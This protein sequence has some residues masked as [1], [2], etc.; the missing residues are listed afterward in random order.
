MRCA[1]PGF[2]FLI[3]FAMSLCAQ[4]PPPAA[5]NLKDKADAAQGTERVSLSLEYAHR[6]LE[7]ANR[8]YTDGDV[9]KAESAIQDVFT[10]AQR[11]TVAATSTNKKLKQ[12]EIDLRKLEHRMHD[13]AQSLNVDD[14]PPVEKTVQQLEDLRA[15]LLAKM[16]GQK[17]EPG[18]KADPKDKPQ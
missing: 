15:N 7:E 18:Q 6:Q 4:A 11:A 9:E 17:A 2:V 13:I 5:S 3:F 8:L 16:F 12:T 10:Y 1:R 14:R